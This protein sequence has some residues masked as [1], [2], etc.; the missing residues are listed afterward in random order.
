MI[1]PTN[2]MSGRDLSA[3]VGVCRDFPRGLAGLGE[4]DE[5]D[6]GTKIFD[7][8]VVRR[9]G[10]D[11]KIPEY[12]KTLRGYS[13]FSTSLYKALQGYTSVYKAICNFSFFVL[14]PQRIRLVTSA[15][16][17]WRRVERTGTC[18]AVG[19]IA[20]MCKSLQRY[21]QGFRVEIA[22]VCKPL[23]GYASVCKAI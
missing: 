5:N 23:Q 2:G 15:A 3:F 4:K 9:R 1:I 21:V 12:Y 11:K 6:R 22:R 8:A 19:P 13:G 20:G 14:L 17:Q 7:A 16:T 10:Q 18:K